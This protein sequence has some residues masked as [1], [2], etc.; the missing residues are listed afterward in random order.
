MRQHLDEGH[1]SLPFT[2]NI[3]FYNGPQ[4]YQGPVKLVEL[5]EH[6]ELAKQY[7]LEAYYLVNLRSDS[8]T[9]IK[10]DKNATLSELA[11]QQGGI[12]K[13]FCD[14]LDKQ[15]ALL[16]EPYCV[17]SEA[18]YLY[19]LTIGSRKAISDRIDKIQG[20]TPRTIS[21]AC[22]TA[23]TTRRYVYQGARHGQ[24]HTLYSSLSYVDC[25][26]SYRIEPGRTHEVAG[27]GEIKS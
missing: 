19:I 24:E 27:R 17:Y 12:S 22:S 18:M 1:T 4:F 5:Y 25:S 23:I 9:K 2:V 20:P 11:L 7:L 16:S 15:E 10:E 21:H 3:C 26:T 13:D 8:V 6:P 14:W